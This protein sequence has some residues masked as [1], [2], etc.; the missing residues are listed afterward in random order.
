[1][2]P[3]T[4]DLSPLK[5]HQAREPREEERGGPFQRGLARKEVES[6][7]FNKPWDCQ[8]VKAGPFWGQPRDR[9]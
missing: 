3:P 9:G 8:Q 2:P 6:A 1:M 4:Y 7:P 5:E